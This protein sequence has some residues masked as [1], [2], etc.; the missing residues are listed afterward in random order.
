[1]RLGRKS[2]GTS[3]GRVPCAYANSPMEIVMATKKVTAS[4]PK[5][6]LSLKDA[7]RIAQGNSD[8][9]GV[10]AISPPKLRTI[11]LRLV[12]DVPLVVN[13]FGN[14]A[15]EQMRTAQMAGSA[16]KNK[17]HKEPKDPLAL[18]EDAKHISTEGWEGVAASAF[19]AAAISACRLVGFKM[20]LAKLSLFIPA[21]GF[22]RVDGVPLVRI[23]GESQ[24]VEHAVRNA[25]GVADLR[26][27]PMYRKWYI[28]LGVQ[29]DADQFTMPDVVNLFAR[30]G[31]QIG[32][33]EGRPDSKSS[34]G[35]GWGLFHLEESKEGA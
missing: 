11:E 21:Q 4:K 15:R 18:F 24:M 20:T 29:W 7:I 35:M 34:A 5:R 17:R 2:N 14:K 12:G 8:Q 31:S 22:D 30:V 27:R 10:V 32:I 13:S 19:R 28:D 1:M 16:G 6:E 33:C 23:H 26:Y 9:D 25:T 3:F